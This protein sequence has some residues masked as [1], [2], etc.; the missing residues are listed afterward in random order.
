MKKIAALTLV[1]L[2]LLIMGCAEAE[3]TGTQSIEPGVTGIVEGAPDAVE[4]EGI[5][6][7]LTGDIMFDKSV[8][9]VFK[10]KGGDYIF[11]GYGK[12]L[13]ESDMV[14]G[15]LETALSTIGQPM[16]DKE[17]TFRSS[18]QAAEA[19]KQY[20]YTALSVAN[21][22]VLDFG[23]RAFI[24]TLKALENNGVRYSGGGYNRHEA[25]EGV[26]IEKNGIKVG[27]VAFTRVVPSVD[28]YAG[29]R[30]PGIIGA[31][32]VHEAVVLDTIKSL[33]SQC[34]ILVVS[35]H[36]GKEGSVTVRKEEVEIAHKMVDSGADII[37][38]HHPHVVQPIEMYKGKPIFY[39]LGNFIFTTSHSELCNKTMVATV[40]V[41]KEKKIE[42]V[43]IVP[44]IIKLGRPFPMEDKQRK[45]FIEYLNR[46]NI[47]LKLE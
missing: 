17:Y 12:Y 5:S 26:F 20:N 15:N 19:L 30:K 33:K 7:S 2:F 1:F 42:S 28:W 40:K 44:G 18:P 27:F 34:D 10:S 22:H 11:E 41:D 35:V 37:T 31:Y 38:G 29:T 43:K 4:P 16:K 21:N 13:K 32:K 45:E 8:G 25:E 47:N 14:F 24:D 39:S 6:I 46:M 36:W 9:A 23:P 3:D